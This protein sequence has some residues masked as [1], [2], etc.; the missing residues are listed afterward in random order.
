MPGIVSDL[1]RRAPV[2]WIF[3]WLIFFVPV[4]VLLGY[5]LHDPTLTGI[6]T[7]FHTAYRFFAT[8][9]LLYLPLLLA[10]LIGFVVYRIRARLF[11]PED[12]RAPV[13]PLTITTIVLSNNFHL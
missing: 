5:V 11:V 8:Y 1:K 6:Q 12:E 4:W 7:G 2:C 10:A 3:F 9:L 13:R